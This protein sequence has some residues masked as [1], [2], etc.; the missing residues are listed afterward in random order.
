MTKPKENEQTPNPP[1]SSLTLA[2]PQS[3]TPTPCFALASPTKTD[4]VLPTPHPVLRIPELLA[5]IFAFLSPY[6]VIQHASLVCR[7][8]LDVSRRFSP[9]P[10]VVATWSAHMTSQESLE[11]F[12]KVLPDAK[13]LHIVSARPNKNVEK[14]S[15]QGYDY[16]WKELFK[17][18]QDVSKSN[19]LAKISRLVFEGF[20]PL[21]TSVP[22]RFESLF[23]CSVPFA[24]GLQEVRIE[25]LS[26]FSRA[27]FKLEVILDA[28]PM[29]RELSLTGR[30]GISTSEAA[31]QVVLSKDHAL[32]TRTASDRPLALQSLTMKDILVSWRLLD[33]VT[34]ASPDLVKLE[35]FSLHLE[36]LN[37]E[38]GILDAAPLRRIAFFHHIGQ[39]CPRL[40]F[41]QISI[42]RTL[43]GA[44]EMDDFRSTFAS[45]PNWSF[46]RTDFHDEGLM[47]FLLPRQPTESQAAALSCLRGLEIH[48]EG[49][50]TGIHKALHAYLIS[51]LAA[52]LVHL[53]V[54]GAN[55]PLSYF[56]SG[57]LAPENAWTCK[58][59]QTLHLRSHY[60]T[61]I[62]SPSGISQGPANQWLSR[63][64]FIG[65]TGAFQR[66]K[67]LRIDCPN[68]DFSLEGGMCLLRRM[69]DLERLRIKSMREGQFTE[70]DLAW[71]LPD[72]TPEQR[73]QNA[74][75]LAGI[76]EQIRIYRGGSGGRVIPEKMSRGYRRRER[77]QS[78]A[79]TLEQV[80]DL[81]EEI[82]TKGV[83]G[84]CLPYLESFIIEQGGQWAAETDGPKQARTREIVRRMQAS[85]FFHLTMDGAPP[86]LGVGP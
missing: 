30:L 60:E 31:V 37:A 43:L 49:H 22:V 70:R 1:L 85:F 5:H 69:S 50:H 52:T 64:L 76:Q 57:F 4:T 44:N 58:G 62:L 79:G 3:E 20:Q 38:T 9:L 8:W 17:Q 13:V 80:A 47:N 33:T 59:L 23:K 39:Y 73:V 82:Q 11:L 75:I 68:N 6:V 65:L 48:R 81:L 36:P 29:L 35:L 54:M 10:P 41:V 40:E 28:C 83:A 19:G 18:V 45:V 7:D 12:T 42:C 78:S 26:K 14:R 25:N 61:G 21:E 34:G 72:P 67:D 27:S 66:I 55:Y 15:P 63:H 24:N 77:D 51:P 86:K 74:K 16:V 46:S 84:R 56:E 2:E 53:K 32:W 71:L